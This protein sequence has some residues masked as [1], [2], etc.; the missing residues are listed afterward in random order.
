MKRNYAILSFFVTLALIFIFTGCRLPSE[1]FTLSYHANGAEGTPPGP[2][3][4]MEYTT[5]N[6]ADKGD[7]SYAGKY[8]D[9]WSTRPGGTWE[10]YRPGDSIKIYFDDITLYA[11]W[12][13]IIYTYTVSYNANNGGGTVPAS[14]TI[15]SGTII[16]IAGQ[17][18][19]TYLGKAFGGWNTKADGTGTP[20]TANAF[21]IVDEDI[22]LYAQW[23]AITYTVTYNANYGI[24]TTESQTVDSGNS[25]IVADGTG[26]QRNGYHFGGWNTKA[27]GTGTPYAANASLTVDKDIVLYA[28]WLVITYTITYN[29]NSGIG[30]PESQSVDRGNSIILAD[31]TGLQRSGYHFGGWNTNILGTGTGYKAGSS[32]TPTGNS[33]NI[34]LYAVWIAPRIRTGDAYK[35]VTSAGGVQISLE[36][37]NQYIF[38]ETEEYRLYRSDTQTGPYSIVAVA[39][40]SYQFITDT[41]VDWF[42]TGY[43]YYKVTAV[44]NG[45]EAM[46]TNGVRIYKSFPKV[47]MRYSTISSLYGN[48]G[49]R[50]VNEDGN[51]YEWAGTTNSSRPGYEL[52]VTPPA[53]GFPPMPAN[54]SLYTSIS[55][56]LVPEAMYWSHQGQ[57]AIRASHTYTIYAFSGSTNSSF[58][59]A[60]W[61]TF[62]P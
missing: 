8:F 32:F 62:T 34:T 6:V 11:Q 41:T 14:Q 2:Q 28:Q 9:G 49:V 44:A 55:S 33:T 7:L 22:V 10:K 27:D 19:L 38:D 13:D 48:C 12:S 26:L 56:P 42:T 17:G 58:D 23:F 24:G 36:T 3:K 50:L 16:K 59:K 18:S 30:T 60:L 37:G 4:V 35:T 21:L 54:Y 1:Y 40:P 39:E 5:A 15:R 20:Y 43:I 46:S 51:W 61:T 29:A 57:L 47:Y 52:L 53:S 25:I 45:V 31:G